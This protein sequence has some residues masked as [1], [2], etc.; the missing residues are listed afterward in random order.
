MISIVVSSGCVNDDDP[1]PNDCAQDGVACDNDWECCLGLTC[2]RGSCAACVQEGE[3]CLSSPECCGSRVCVEGLCSPAFDRDY[4]VQIAS[5]ALSTSSSPGVLWDDDEPEGHREPDPYV[6][7]TIGETT[8]ETEVYPDSIFPVVTETFDAFIQEGSE[9]RVTLMDADDGE[10]EVVFDYPAGVRG[11][12]PLANL[13]QGGIEVRSAME[14]RTAV[15]MLAF[16]P[17]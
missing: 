10:D 4:T 2:Q 7:V 11:T 8:F 12:V 14:G 3:A 1:E 17:R 6:I 15:V 16:F 9:F 5:V 13:R